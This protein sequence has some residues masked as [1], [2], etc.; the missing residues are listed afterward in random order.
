MGLIIVFLYKRPTQRS[1]LLS[2]LLFRW[3]HQVYSISTI[4]HDFPST[5]L[6]TPLPLMTN[7]ILIFFY[8][9]LTTTYPVPQNSSSCTLFTEYPKTKY[10]TTYL[11]SRRNILWNLLTV[12][13]PPFLPSTQI[14]IRTTY[15]TWKFYRFISTMCPSTHESLPLI[16]TSLNSIDNLNISKYFNNHLV[17]ISFFSNHLIYPPMS[18]FSDVSSLWNRRS[19][20]PNFGS[21]VLWHLPFPIFT[22]F[23]T[24]FFSSKNNGFSFPQQYFTTTFLSILLLI[25]KVT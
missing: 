22:S 16:Q 20:Y 15:T 14:I 12:Q 2:R 7:W 21:F 24:V 19:L 10:V 13:D 6:V 4:K 3:P 9:Y 17:Y 11:Y 8:I 1:N 5:L 18:A 25:W 23:I